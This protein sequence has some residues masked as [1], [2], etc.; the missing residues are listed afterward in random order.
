M[1]RFTDEIPGLHTEPWIHPVT[2]RHYYITVINSLGEWIAYVDGNEVGRGFQTEQGALDFAVERLSAK[3]NFLRLGLKTGLATGIAAGI[4]TAVFALHM[5]STNP[6]PSAVTQNVSEK[7]APG[8]KR[9]YGTSANSTPR[10]NATKVASTDQSIPLSIINSSAPQ[11]RIVPELPTRQTATPASDTY[12]SINNAELYEQI[13]LAPPHPLTA[14]T[15]HNPVLGANAIEPSTSPVSETVLDT[16]A[17]IETTDLTPPPPTPARRQARVESKQTS[18]PGV[19]ARQSAKLEGKPLQFAPP[20][21]RGPIPLGNIAATQTTTPEIE[22][23]TSQRTNSRKTGALPSSSTK[24][25]KKTKAKRKATKKRSSG[26]RTKSRKPLVKRVI[27]RDSY[28][29]KHVVYYVRRPRNAR[30]YRQF[31]RIRNRIIARELRRRRAYY[32]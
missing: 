19:R 14:T 12:A 17:F 26:R 2:G 7:S 15:A 32:R 29:R 5:A 21:K 25:E 31:K 30:E 27:R 8:S 3:A 20:K 9:S 23:V 6:A 1:S 4:C 16:D 18:S 10:V 11:S 22:P 13:S 24:T 28:G